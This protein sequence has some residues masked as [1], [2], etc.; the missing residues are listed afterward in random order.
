MMI[1]CFSSENF[2]QN[3]ITRCFVRL[4]RKGITNIVS[5]VLSFGMQGCHVSKQKLRLEDLVCS[6]LGQVVCSQCILYEYVTPN[7]ADKFVFN[8]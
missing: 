1:V 4:M 7:V 8:I 3:I 5:L 6:S 2:K